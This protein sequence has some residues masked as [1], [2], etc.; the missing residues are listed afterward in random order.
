[1]PHLAERD[2]RALLFSLPYRCVRGCA[3]EQITLS[4]VY[5]TNVTK[6]HCLDS[7]MVNEVLIHVLEK[8]EQVSLLLRGGMTN[9]VADVDKEIGDPGKNLLVKRT[10]QG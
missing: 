6:S 1:M 8:G 4:G 7:S 9:A 2:E 10:P 5:T 3:V